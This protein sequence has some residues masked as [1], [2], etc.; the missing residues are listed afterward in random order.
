MQKILD[1]FKDI[2]TDYLIAKLKELEVGYNLD[3]INKF[4]TETLKDLPN[5]GNT[6]LQSQINFMEKINKVFK[7]PITTSI[8]NSLVELRN[9]KQKQ[10]EKLKSE[11]K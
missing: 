5:T 4:V 1:K 9:I 7:T 8:L 10:I 11:L 2:P 6:K 3:D